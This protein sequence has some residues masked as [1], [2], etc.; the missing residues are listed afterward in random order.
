MEKEQWAFCARGWASQERRSQNAHFAPKHVFRHI[1]SN[2]QISGWGGL[3]K[4]LK[5]IV[6]RD[7]SKKK[8]LLKM[9]A[10]KKV[11]RNL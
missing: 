6:C 10:E 2:T 5:K 7:K 11:C 4:K 9:W 8:K 3:R 1:S